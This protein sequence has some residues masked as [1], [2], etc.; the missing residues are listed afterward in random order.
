[1]LGNSLA[2]YGTYP[3]SDSLSHL[4]APDRPSA[5]LRRRIEDDGAA[6]EQIQARYQKEISQIFSGLET[7]GM[8]VHR[9]AWEDY[10]AF[11]ERKYN[12]EELLRESEAELPPAESRG[13]AAAKSKLEI[14]EI[15]RAHV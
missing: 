15:G 13:G 3:A 2:G 6:L 8:A 14:F 12:R 4:S 11:L 7:R 9:E 10:V 1:M 5:G